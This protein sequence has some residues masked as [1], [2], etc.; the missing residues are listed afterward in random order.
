MCEEPPPSQTKVISPPSSLS[1]PLRC[2]V[3]FKSWFGILGHGIRESG[4]GR[5][6]VGVV[7]GRR[8]LQIVDL[9]INGRD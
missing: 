3:Q 5:C 2:V 7:G 1:I 6:R 4:N 8:H 9:E